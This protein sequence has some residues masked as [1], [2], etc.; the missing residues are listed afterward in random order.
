M[1]PY[2]LEQIATQP[3]V[4]PLWYVIDSAVLV[5]WFIIEYDTSLSL[6]DLSFKTEINIFNKSI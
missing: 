5:F 4:Q 3:L 6:L 1:R 2:F